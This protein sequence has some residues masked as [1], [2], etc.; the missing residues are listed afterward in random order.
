MRVPYN[1]NIVRRPVGPIFDRVAVEPQQAL[2]P[3]LTYQQ[4]LDARRRQERTDEALARRLQRAAL[5]L[6]N[7]DNMQQR[8]A[9]EVWG[10][11]NAGTHFMN[12][13]F[14]QT[15]AN[16]VIESLG[17]QFGR[18]GERE[19]G[20]RRRTDVHGGF[21]PVVSTGLA[22]DAFGT[23]S[24]LGIG[25][26]TAP[27]LA[28]LAMRGTASNGPELPNAGRQNERRIGDWLGRVQ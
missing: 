27:S 24:V 19:S 8:H 20:R 7:E 26:A 6:E 3:A 5:G 22:P 4:E 2:N 18:R 11:G 17:E 25:P 14:M 23:E 1:I 13:D 9:T 21:G 28:T 16:L 12:E 15:A 10:F